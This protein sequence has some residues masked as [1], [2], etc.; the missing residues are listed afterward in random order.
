MYIAIERVASIR[1]KDR[2]NTIKLCVNVA[3]SLL[4]QSQSIQKFS[5]PGNE[6]ENVVFRAINLLISL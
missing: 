6:D 3:K 4:E 1:E 2:A 5:N